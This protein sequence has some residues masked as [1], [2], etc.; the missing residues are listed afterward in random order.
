MKQII[1]FSI[2]LNL[3]GCYGC[4]PGLKQE[5]DPTRLDQQIKTLTENGRLDDENASLI[6]WYRERAG[7][8]RLKGKSFKDLIV[9]SQKQLQGDLA[10]WDK[11]KGDARRDLRSLLTVSADEF[12][13]LPTPSDKGSAMAINRLLKPEQLI[14][15]LNDHMKSFESEPMKLYRAAPNL[16]RTV[17]KLAV[18]AWEPTFQHLAKQAGI[19]PASLRVRQEQESLPMVRNW[20]KGRQQLGRQERARLDLSLSLISAVGALPPDSKSSSAPWRVAYGAWKRCGLGRTGARLKALAIATRAYQ[21]RLSAAPGSPKAAI[22]LLQARGAMD[23]MT[24]ACSQSP[25]IP[26]K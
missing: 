18:V 25:K 11:A 14:D 1:L 24:Q 8:S 19:I 22:G 12:P 23:G 7:S 26:K 21:D 2:I 6:K 9:L 20:V 4:G 5:A 10:N 16:S 13:G 17:N 3:F 15:L